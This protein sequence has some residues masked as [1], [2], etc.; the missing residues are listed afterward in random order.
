M[1]ILRGNFSLQ[2]AILGRPTE[3]RTPANSQQDTEAL[4]LSAY[5]ELNNAQNQA[6]L[7]SEPSPIN[8]QTTPQPWL[9]PWL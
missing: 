4:N 9:M 3:Q 1:S 7:K 2:G 6:S 5:R 8:P